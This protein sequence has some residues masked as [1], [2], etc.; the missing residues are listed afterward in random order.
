MASVNQAKKA[1]NSKPH[2][3]C[4][5]GC[6]YVSKEPGKC[7]TPG[8]VRARNPLSLCQCLDGRHSHL[9]NLNNSRSYSTKT[10]K[11]TKT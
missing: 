10:V 8:C 6:R 3:V 7:S 2:Y 1:V 11:T 4:T 9:V 5:G